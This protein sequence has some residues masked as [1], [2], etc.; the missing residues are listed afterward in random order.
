[1]FVQN[2]FKVS[3]DDGQAL[4]VARGFGTL[5]AHDGERLHASH[6]PFLYHRDGNGLG[7]IA[8]HVAKPNP[9]HG[10]FATHPTALLVCQGADAYISP[11]WYAS[12][13]QVPTWNYVTVHVSGSVRALPAAQS[14]AHLDALS[15]HFEARLAPKKPWTT[16]KMTP[17]RL[18][19]M[20]NG[21][22]PL[23]MTVERIEP[24]WKLGQQKSEADRRGAIAALRERPN[25]S[26]QA[27]AALMEQ[28]LRARR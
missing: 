6:L 2:A 14:R 17:K 25:E 16:D 26:A 13:D 28:A 20:L 18:D 9:L 5:V 11:D 3:L 21:I 24:S 19:V 15:A 10:I 4:L 23:E 8:F 1:M 27:I 12:E 22:V 7:K